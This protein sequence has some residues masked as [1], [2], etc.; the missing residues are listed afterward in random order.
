MR[1]TF[2]LSTLMGCVHFFTLFANQ[3]VQNRQDSA[4]IKFSYSTSSNLSLSQQQ[5]NDWKE[6]EKTVFDLK[7]SLKFMSQFTTSFCTLNTGLRMNLGVTRDNSLDSIR[8]WYRTTDN[9]VAGEA[10][11]TIPLG[12]TIDPFFNASFKTQVTE[13]QKLVKTTIQRTANLWDPVT[14]EQSLGFCYRYDGNSG[15]LCLRT[16]ANLQQIRADES[17]TLTD[18]PKTRSILERYKATAGMECVVDAQFKLDSLISYTGK[19]T[20][21]KDMIS[22]SPWQLQWENELRI[23]VWKIF[24]VI[25]TANASYNELISKRMQFK[26]STMFGLLVD[27]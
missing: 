20:S 1:S 10:R 24:G 14:S 27:F 13:A 5:V 4:P 26:Q 6:G 21:R 19:W 25:I 2:I 12:W 8:V 18:D 17:T 9:E 11:L 7:S 15:F 22:D 16:G 3:T 23:R